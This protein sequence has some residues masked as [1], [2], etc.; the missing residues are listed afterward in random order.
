[1]EYTKYTKEQW[2]GSVITSPLPPTLVTCG[3]MDKPNVFT[4]AW[5]GI[6]C[7]QPPVTYIS[8]RPERYSHELITQSGEFV[9]NLPT[10]ELVK[11]VD[12]CGVKTGRKV[13]KFKEM[14][15]S[16]KFTVTGILLDK[17][18]NNEF[19]LKKFCK[20]IYRTSEMCKDDIELDIMKDRR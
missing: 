12:W 10:R 15:S 2:K 11:A 17:G 7:T 6:L 8:V 16:H 9:I 14:Q 18:K 5:T 20:K 3:S 13:D 4:V 19:S 1:M